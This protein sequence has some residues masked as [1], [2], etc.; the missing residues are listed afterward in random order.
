MKTRLQTT[1]IFFL[2]LSLFILSCGLVSKATVTPVNPDL[3]PASQE[4]QPVVTPEETATSTAVSHPGSY[5]PFGVYIYQDGN[6]GSGLSMGGFAGDHHLEVEYS[7][8]ICSLDKPFTLTDPDGDYEVFQFTPSGPDAGSVSISGGWVLQ[9]A[10]QDGEGVTDG[11]LYTVE[12][13]TIDPNILAGNLGLH[14]I[15]SPDCN[16]PTD[17]VLSFRLPN[18][19]CFQH[20]SSIYISPVE[21]TTECAQP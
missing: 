11:G 6:F 7:G 1:S 10:V 8:V 16:S 3:P 5:A 20:D 14:I 9:R 19:G 12:D 2:I 4:S 18:E 17:I 15:T 21:T 13:S